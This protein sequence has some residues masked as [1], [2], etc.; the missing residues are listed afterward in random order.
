MEN[1]SPAELDELRLRIFDNAESLYK[2]SKL[3]FDAG[4]YPRAYLLA[5]FCIEEL[6]KIPIIVGVVAKLRNGEVVEWDQVKKRW[7]SH[8]KKVDSNTHH[9]YVFGK[10]LDLL[11][12]TDVAWFEEHVARS[13]EYADRKNAATYVDVK[14][15]KTELPI[16]EITKDVAQRHI[17]FAFESLKAH[18]NSECFSNTVLADAQE[19]SHN[20]TVQP[21][22]VPP[23]DL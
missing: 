11:R 10:E 3:L 12:N 16:T 20:K 17:G 6:G 22:G 5:H 23:A 18:W 9:H 21:S 14:N 7:R 1:L 19:M 4:F 15:G 13:S 8:A 2:E